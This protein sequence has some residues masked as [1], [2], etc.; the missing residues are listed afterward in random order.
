MQI[1]VIAVPSNNPILCP[2]AQNRHTDETVKVFNAPL[3]TKAPSG[4]TKSRHPESL[5]HWMSCPA[6][7]IFAAEDT[8]W[9][10]IWLAHGIYALYQYLASPLH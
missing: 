1:I 2:I 7:K 9:A 10:S 5:S 6:V 3:S 4:S 8:S